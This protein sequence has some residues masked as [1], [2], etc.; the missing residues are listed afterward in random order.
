M[1]STSK[2]STP[3]VPKVGPPMVAVGRS[4]LRGATPVSTNK[5]GKPCTPIDKK[6]QVVFITSEV[7]PWSKTGGLGE[8][9]D[10]LPVALAALGHRVMTISPRYDQYEEGWD[11]GY[12]S[13]VPMGDLTEPVHAFHCSQSKVDRVFVD[14][15]CFLAKATVKTGS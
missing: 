10:G 4:V 1:G 14:H 12:W 15:D 5:A 13:H 11:T 6:Y 3:S 2:V 9:M 8:A 7:A